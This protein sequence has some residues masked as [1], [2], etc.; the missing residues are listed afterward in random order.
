M[1]RAFVLTYAIISISAVSPH[2]ITT[3]WVAPAPYSLSDARLC[4]R[5]PTTARSSF[6]RLNL[7]VQDKILERLRMARGNNG[8]SQT[9]NNGVVNGNNNQAPASS[10]QSVPFV[11]QK[12]GRGTKSEIKEI[13]QMTID[14]FFN[15]DDALANGGEVNKK[16]TPPWK[17]AQ[18]AYLR[19][20]QQGDILARNAFKK[21]QLVDLVIARRVYAVDW[22]DATNINGN[23][24]SIIDDPNQIYNL[25]QLMY[26]QNG[27]PVKYITGEVI[28]YSE[29]SEKK[30]GLG[31]NF[32]SNKKNKD[33][34]EPRPYLSN[35]SVVEYARQ[36]G[37][38]T[39][40]MDACEEAVRDWNAGHTEIVLQVEEDNP[41]A[42][43]FYKR[44][45]WEFVFADPTCRR[46]DTSGF[47][48]KESR[49]T[50][51]AMV[52]RLGPIPNKGD[53]GE[54]DAGS[55]FI[56]KLRNSFFVQ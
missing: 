14:V 12:I 20:F 42:I 30:F 19:N 27:S 29:V 50:K 45:G 53:G 16:Q 40:L 8:E 46:Y 49:I 38:G 1:I 7:A 18:L 41:S 13:T 51:Y 22:S 24:A 5:A 47:F 11:I 2:D 10:K 32:E 26:T 48:L 23:K 17:A 44:R 21:D 33:G 25:D 52:K 43:Q 37:V 15:S 56:S 31:G 4:N 28:G 39:K 36:S 6:S 34:E 54:S 35:L 3:F 9:R 55:S